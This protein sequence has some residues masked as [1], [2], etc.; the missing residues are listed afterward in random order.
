MAA[1]VRERELGRARQARR[2]ARIAEQAAPIPDRYCLSCRASFQPKRSDSWLCSRL[3]IDRVSYHRKQARATELAAIMHGVRQ[4]LR[5]TP[6]PFRLE[7]LQARWLYDPLPGEVA[8]R[9]WFPDLCGLTPEQAL[10]DR[11]LF[12]RLAGSTGEPS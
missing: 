5:G 6:D 1:S 2:R 10:Q 7:D 8:Y 9:L 4:H 12:Q 11:E 3:C